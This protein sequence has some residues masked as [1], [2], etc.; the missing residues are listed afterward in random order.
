[1][2]SRLRSLVVKRQELLGGCIVDADFVKRI[3]EAYE[4]ISACFRSGHKLLIFGNGG[5]AAEAQHF[6]G[7]LVCQFSH[8]RRALPAIALTADTS[9]LTA[10]SNDYGFQTIF[11]RQIQALGNKGDVVVGM[12]TSDASEDEAHSL[13]ILR[14]FET[15]QRMGLDS[16]GLFS[17]KTQNLLR[18]VDVTICVPHTNTALIQEAHLMIVHILSEMIEEEY[19]K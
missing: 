3:E 6:A 11:S 10:Q 9:I 19:I 8:N 2:V 15:A 1:M 5:S 16:I 18:Y 17:N 7:E 12:T 4:M 14:A 13:N